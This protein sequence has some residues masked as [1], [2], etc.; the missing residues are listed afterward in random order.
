MHPSNSVLLAN[1]AFHSCGQAELGPS[2][3]EPAMRT[4][5]SSNSAVTQRIL[6]SQRV[7][8]KGSVWHFPWGR[9]EAAQCQGLL[10]LCQRIRL[11]VC[12]STFRVTWGRAVPLE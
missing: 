3:A 12:T 11:T 8:E 9:S 4:A 1:S 5:A 10:V 6:S 2:R 7:S